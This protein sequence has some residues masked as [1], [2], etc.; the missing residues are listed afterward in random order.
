MKKWRKR[1]SAYVPAPLPCKAPFPS[2]PRRNYERN[3]F[4]KQDDGLGNVQS[5]GNQAAHSDRQE[6]VPFPQLHDLVVRRRPLYWRAIDEE[7]QKHQRQR[8]ENQKSEIRCPKSDRFLM[9]HKRLTIES[10][11]RYQMSERTNSS[12]S[13]P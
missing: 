7:A 2:S 1:P 10:D 6:C 5:P 11:V 13:A 12:P 8:R 9:H 3:R 4:S